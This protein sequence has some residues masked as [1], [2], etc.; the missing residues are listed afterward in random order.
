M[1]F[2]V[3]V[4]VYN[5]EKYLSKCLDSIIYQTN[6]DFELIVVNDGTKDNSQNIIDEY[7]KKYPSKVKGFIKENGGLSDARN[8]G[9]K[10]ASGEYIVFVDSDDYIDKKL[11]EKLDEEIIKY[12][13]LDVIGYNYV[14]MT[15]NDERIKVTTRPKKSNISGEE[16]ISELILGKQY[17]EPAWGFA[18][19]LEYWREND[20]NYIK[21][22]Y[23][24]DFA[25]TPIVV[26]KAKHVSFIDF[27]GYYYIITQNSITRNPNKE[28][29]RRLAEDLLKG[30]DF[31]KSEFEK[32]GI[33]N[34]YTE[35]LFMSYIAC[36][37]IYRLQNL[38]KDL[39][40]WYRGELKSRNIGNYI[41]NDTFKRK[42]RKFL[43]RIKNRI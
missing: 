5:V 4:P 38:S 3:I 11:L 28:K 8:F 26:A 2:S 35:R 12:E 41:M 42:V 21:G 40:N 43:I 18:Y 23:H 14:D 25:L 24:E 30:Y 13:N 22:L 9:V 20:F 17:F 7:V 1:R 15:Q 37:A 33:S 36:S 34:N 29:E 31:L 27:D 32:I 6:Q 10:R 16:A 19:R 39:Q